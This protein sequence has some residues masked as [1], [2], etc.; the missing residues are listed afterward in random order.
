METIPES[1]KPLKLNKKKVARKTHVIPRVCL[2]RLV[3]EITQKHAD[4]YI[5]SN[6]AMS[7][8]Q[9]SLEAYIEQRFRICNNVA[10]LCKKS[11]INKEIFDFFDT[12]L[13]T[14]S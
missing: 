13:D 14:L 11:T 8:V 6:E 3:K 2:A 1:A 12:Y 9:E 7:A 4:K 5:W 10:K